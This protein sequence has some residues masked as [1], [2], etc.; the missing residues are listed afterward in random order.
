MKVE[1]IGIY[2]ACS[3]EEVGTYSLIESQ[4]E[5]CQC[6]CKPEI[7][8]RKTHSV[9]ICVRE[10]NKYVTKDIKSCIFVKKLCVYFILLFL[11]FNAFP[12]CL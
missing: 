9:F 4:M 11:C 7:L 6:D 1:C 12:F 10:S 5:W 3:A 2:F 8:M